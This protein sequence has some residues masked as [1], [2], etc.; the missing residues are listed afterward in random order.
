MAMPGQLTLPVFPL[1]RWL[2][3]FRLEQA[4]GLPAIYLPFLLATG[5]LLGRVSLFGRLHPF[6]LALVGVF[7]GTGASAEALLA[8]LGV[9][10]GITSISIWRVPEYLPALLLLGTV[11]WRRIPA[12]TGLALGRP[13][14]ER[15]QG[16]LWAGALAAVATALGRIGWTIVTRHSALDVVLLLF[17]SLG[18]G[19]LAA[20]LRQSVEAAVHLGRERR[21]EREELAGLALLVTLLV[22][23]LEG[24]GI[25]TLSLQDAA[26]RWTVLTAAWGAGAGAGAVAGTV[27]GCVGM[28]LGNVPLYFVSAYALAGILGGMVREWGKPAVAGGFVLGT[29]ILTY[30]IPHVGELTE[31]LVGTGLAILAFAITPAGAA[32]MIAMGWPPARV[33][34]DVRRRGQVDHLEEAFARRLQDF[35]RVFKELA[36]IFRCTPPPT[37][38]T[39]RP[40]LAGL[41]EAVAER[42]CVSCS[43]A[44]VCWK[45]R[46]YLTYRNVAELLTTAE[47]LGRATLLDVPDGLRGCPQVHKVVSAVNQ[48]LEL[49]KVNTVWER[50]VTE[51]KE[52]VYGQLN[53]VA[54]LMES[55]AREARL[56]TGSSCEEWEGDV[57]AVLA[58]CG[59]PVEQVSATGLGG[60]RVAFEV[61]RRPCDGRE[62]CRRLIPR[63]LTSSVGQAYSLYEAECGRKSERDVCALRYLPERAYDL[64]VQVAKRA[65]G[66]G[67]VCGDSHAVIDLPGGKTS[68]ML[69]DG[70]GIG[71]EAALESAAA[72]DVLTQLMKAGFEREFAV[73]TVN[74]ILLLRSPGESFATVDMMLFDLYSGEAE[75]V[76]IGACPTYI[77]RD[78]D[79]HVIQ[80]SSLPA[81]ILSAIDVE[82]NRRMLRAGDLVVM[83]TDGVLG[84]P[85]AGS[86]AADPGENADWIPA[87]LA[88]I[89]D[90]DPAVV[91]QQLLAQARLSCGEQTGDD[92]TV[93]VCQVRRRA[94]YCLPH[95]PSGPWQ[96]AGAV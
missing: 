91:A 54:E 67:P 66:D 85:A 68:V 96:D 14:E 87:A 65:G 62:D 94:D 32:E 58:R 95:S 25:K 17:E 89:G 24:Y 21:L 81:G 16:L 93:L 11:A 39:G 63:L 71:S 7:A 59:V 9:L 61:R 12:A 3:P 50:K 79:V 4:T 8:G 42:A 38:G 47:T 44:T 53:G 51:S 56:G 69:S 75:F 31:V 10:T 19:L 76:K 33:R 15:W 45:D 74:S 27:L 26:T 78:G 1:R 72:I 84:E 30:Q 70:M 29:L 83:V 64:V 57:R 40:E 48:L 35:S 86:A 73:R 18:A 13:G 55:L 49:N 20:L 34:A 43:D 2:E 41:M 90:A 37:D 80:R 82:V 28:L 5:F 23:G 36:R 88:G 6:G 22:A 60:G 92:M 52:I 46:F 77:R